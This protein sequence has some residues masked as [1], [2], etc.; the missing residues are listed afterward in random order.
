MALARLGLD[1]PRL[2]RVD[3]LEFVRLLGT[4]RGADTGP[5]IDPRRTA[6][7]AV[8]RDERDLERFLASHPIA[9]RWE[10]AAEAWHVRLLTVRAHGRWGALAADALP[11]ADPDV[12][13]IG[14][15]VVVL[16]RA[17][18][19]PRATLAFRRASRSF[20]GATGAAAGN[21]AVVGV[22][23]R[24]IARL[25]TV[26]VWESAAAAGDFAL[27]HT[28]HAAAMNAARADGW[29][30]E[31]LFATFAPTRSSGTW[32]GHDPLALP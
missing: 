24:P 15:P 27:H 32:S 8:W 13:D 2:R 4:G 7:F 17:S 16:T 10:R 30:R 25:G 20:G 22:G 31:E 12:A 21:R 5:S 3:G 23:E 26:S 19:R 14:G 18:I 28:E 11:T 9:R 6:M 29:F 1:R